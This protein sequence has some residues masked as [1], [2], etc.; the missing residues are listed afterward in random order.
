MFH[1]SVLL[2]MK[3]EPFCA[4]K[5]LSIQQCEWM[6]EGLKSYRLVGYKYAHVANGNLYIKKTMRVYGVLAR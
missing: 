4:S 5:Y 1:S 3:V 2:Q 6:G